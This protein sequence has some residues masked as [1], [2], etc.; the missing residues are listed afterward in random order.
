MIPIGRL[1]A[2]RG[3]APGV[4]GQKARL[5]FSRHGSAA[6]LSHLKQIEVVRRALDASGWPLARTNAK[7]P[8]LKI[9]F[10]PAISVGYESDCEF[11]DAELRSRIDW[12]A[13]PAQL[14]PHLPAGLS[15]VSARSIPVFFPSLEESVNVA[16]Y[17]L[18]APFLSGTEGRW[19]AFWAAETFPVV[20]KKQDREET[21]DARACVRAWRLEGETLH[22]Q[23]RFGP[24]R[25]L[26]PERIAQAVCGAPDEAVALGVPGATLRVLRER[27]ALEKS[28][29]T[30]LEP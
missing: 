8:K 30:L 13:A 26:K 23:V 4:P 10:G 3:G 2:L 21:V 27:M 7:R 1:S 17:I 5:K 15:L 6:E 19:Q 9:S 28:D 22:L 20:K 16:D 14:A 18:V 25:T 29:G 24:G 11:C 12:A